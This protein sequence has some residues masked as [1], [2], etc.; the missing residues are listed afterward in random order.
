[1]PTELKA[2]RTKYLMLLAISCV[3][4]VMGIFIAIKEPS[5]WIGWVNILFFGLC[6]LV[7]SKQLLNKEARLVFDQEG[8]ID[9]TQR[10][11]GK[12]FWTDIEDAYLA[13]VSGHYFVCLVLNDEAKYLSKLSSAQRLLGKAN[14]KLGFTPISL[15][16][17]GVAVDP[18]EV[19]AHIRQRIEKP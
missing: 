3:F 19:L 11:L 2:S 7:F 6:G 14:T 13:Q 4:V 17:S 1:M 9:T 10:R 8:V 12:V 18:N 16:L 5:S 15:N